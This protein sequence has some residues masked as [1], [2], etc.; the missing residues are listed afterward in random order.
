[1]GPA[2]GPLPA[3]PFIRGD[4]D[5]TKPADITDAIQILG[6]LFLGAPG[7]LDCQ[8][9]ADS[10]DS[11]VLDLSDGVFLLNFLF[12]GGRTLTSPFPSCGDDPTGDGLDCMKA[13]GC[14]PAPCGGIAGLPCSEGEVCDPA[15]GEC[16]IDDGMGECVARPS[17]C[18]DVYIPVCGC[19]GKTYSNDCD[20]LMAGVGKDHDGPCGG[21]CG[22]RGMPPCADNEYCEFPEGT[23]GAADQPGECRLRPLACTKVFDPVCGCDGQTYGNDCERMRAGVS[24]VHRGPCQAVK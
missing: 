16:D 11:G 6:H 22:G 23:C 5:G 8:D 7:H 14:A 13:P 2:A 21:I 12:L 17:G 1:V 15:P 19:D 18:P 24:L 3:A 20:R 4:V 9:A 10:D